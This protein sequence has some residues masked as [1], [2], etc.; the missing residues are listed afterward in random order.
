MKE[1][2]WK[3]YDMRR[4][5]IWGLVE[6]VQLLGKHNLDIFLNISSSVFV[7]VVVCVLVV[8]RIND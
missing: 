8:L 7:D 1:K 2:K 6:V 3:K 5:K 4:L